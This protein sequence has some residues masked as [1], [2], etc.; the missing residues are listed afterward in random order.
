MLKSAQRMSDHV[1]MR[2]EA[3]SEEAIQTDASRDA[4]AEAQEADR[5]VSCSMTS[6]LLRLIRSEG[7][8]AAI[9]ELLEL[10]QAKREVAYLENV[11]NWVSLDEATALLEAG[12]A[13][14]GDPL[15]ARR[16]GE[17]TLRQHA[18]TQVAT[19]LR[20]LGSTEAVL[21]TVAQTAARLSTVTKM[22]TVEAGPGHAVVRALARE[23][24]TRGRLHC[25]WTTGCSRG[26][27]SCSG[28]R[29]RAWRRAN[30][31]RAATG[32]ACTRSPGTPSS[33]PRRPIPSSA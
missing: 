18:G 16:V 4:A 20:S 10:S 33:P 13:Q 30:A 23:G 17:Q 6:V 9:T 12:V 27:R 5:E 2:A 32:S 24:F 3:G 29:S 31:R 28:F 8:E 1:P 21:K 19:V 25:D 14:T 15:F 11:D 22:E 26:R 7:G